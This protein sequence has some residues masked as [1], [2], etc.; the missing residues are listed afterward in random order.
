VDGRQEC[1]G[2]WSLTLRKSSAEA[3][4]NSSEGMAFAT[5]ARDTNMSGVAFT[6][7]KGPEWGLHGE[8]LWAV[9]L[10]ITEGP[11]LKPVQKANESWIIQHIVIE[12]EGTECD[13]KKIEPNK[14]D[15]YE[16]WRVGTDGYA[17]KKYQYDFL[18]DG[19]IVEIDITN[20]DP[21]LAEADDFL[22]N[23]ANPDRKAKLTIDG[24]FYAVD[25]I[26]PGIFA[27]RT[28]KDGAGQ[29]PR[30]T[31]PPADLGR[32]SLT[33]H[34]ECTWES[35]D[36]EHVTGRATAETRGRS[37]TESWEFTG[38]HRTVV[39]EKEVGSRP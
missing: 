16:A 34:V 22:V 30:S 13:G 24:T 26:E 6:T 35:C 19:T 18:G 25:R 39:D 31:T 5:T 8:F 23:S 12:E 17:L 28:T 2:K 4:G 20:R 38:Q 27:L 1:Y 33:R 29:L 11:E 3:R 10:F 9:K 15:Y 32:P 21:A 37:Y 7:I 14:L 36:T